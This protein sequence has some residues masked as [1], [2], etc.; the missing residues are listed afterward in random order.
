MGISKEEI[1][2]NEAMGISTT[3][4]GAVFDAENNIRWNADDLSEVPIFKKPT[5]Y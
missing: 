3:D 1:E 4:A 2:A 5:V